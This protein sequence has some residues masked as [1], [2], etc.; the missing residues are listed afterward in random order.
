MHWRLTWPGQGKPDDGVLIGADGK[1]CA[2]VYFAVSYP[3][4]GWYWAWQGEG[5]PASGYCDTKEA[6]KAECERRARATFR[7]YPQ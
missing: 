1:T 3:G 7:P 4:G 5:P 6:A 2:R